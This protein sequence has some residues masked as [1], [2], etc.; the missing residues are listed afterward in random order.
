MSRTLAGCV[1]AAW[2]VAAQAQGTSAPPPPPI[3]S[4]GQTPI[5]AQPPQ[6]G[7]IAPIVDIRIQGEGI[8][9]PKGVGEA[10]P[11]EKPAEKPAAK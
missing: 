1:V 7:N 2:A 8:S 3:H 9:L 5:T 10:P 4:P 11:P 6:R